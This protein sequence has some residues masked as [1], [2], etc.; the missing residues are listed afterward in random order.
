M[1]EQGP[2]MPL[3]TATEARAMSESAQSRHQ[4][5]LAGKVPADIRDRFASAVLAEKASD[6]LNC[7]LEFDI[8]ENAPVPPICETLEWIEANDYVRA[9]EFQL[10]VYDKQEG[11]ENPL[12]ATRMRIQKTSARNDYIWAAAIIALRNVEKAH[13]GRGIGIGRAALS[14]MFSWGPLAVQTRLTPRYE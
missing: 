7:Y 5:E 12:H 9:S 11:G 4:L 6:F 13:Q 2:H 14:V 10:A 8:S 3:L 1:A